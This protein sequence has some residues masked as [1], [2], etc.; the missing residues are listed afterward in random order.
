MANG[1]ASHHPLHS[2]LAAAAAA[3]PVPQN[4][5]AAAPEALPAA[6][7]APKWGGGTTAA[8]IVRGGPTLP[9]VAQVRRC[10][11][12]SPTPAPVIALPFSSSFIFLHDTS[13]C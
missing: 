7:S 3:A 12:S 11:A 4:S 10:A 13:T 1:D 6:S 8:D 9:P 2:R 5:Y